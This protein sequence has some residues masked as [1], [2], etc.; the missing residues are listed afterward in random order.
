MKKPGPD[1]K[2]KRT[3]TDSE[4]QTVWNAC[5]HKDIPP[6]FGA[7]FR[8]LLVTGQRRNECADM[9]WSE[10]DLDKRTWLLPADRAKNGVANLIHLNDYALE[11]LKGVPR[12]ADSP[13]VFTTKGKT[14]GFGLQ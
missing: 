11:I 3:L 14:S 5:A 6:A 9:Q 8:F 10:I 2:R 12:F 1:I 7:L 13:F 4:I